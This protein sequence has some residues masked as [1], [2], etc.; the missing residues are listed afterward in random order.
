MSC[1]PRKTCGGGSIDADLQSRKSERGNT[2]R[3][4]TSSTT[5]TPTTN[6]AR[7]FGKGEK[8]NMFLGMSE[9]NLLYFIL[10]LMAGSWPL[11]L[12]I[13]W[14]YQKYKQAMKGVDL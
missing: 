4:R 10:G 3:I 6:Q 2:L 12:I 11:T 14:I 8:V 1:L 13:F 9:T 7:Y 5:T